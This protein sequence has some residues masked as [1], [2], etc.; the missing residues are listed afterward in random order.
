LGRIVSALPYGSTLRID[1]GRRGALVVLALLGAATANSIEL[2]VSS[3]SAA[4]SAVKAEGM[5]AGDLGALVAAFEA[6]SVDG[7]VAVADGRFW[8]AAGASEAQELTA[9]LASV[10][11]HL[12]ALAPMPVERAM[13]RVGV[14]LAADADQ[15]MTTA[16]FRAMRLLLDRIAELAGIGASPAKIHAE[17]AWRMMSRREPRMNVL[18][19]TGA[20]FA[21]ATGGAD[22]IAVL[23]FDVL[24][25]AASAA[26][27]RLA[28][29]TQLILAD[30][31][32]LHRFADPG[33]GSGAIE[34]LTD[35]LAEAAWARFQRIE[36][37][38]GL[39]AELR[40]GSLLRE[41]AATRAAR[42]ERVRSGAMKMVGVNA[43][44]EAVAAPS[45][46]PPEA[47][48]GALVFRRLAEDEEAA[49]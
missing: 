2:I 24:D 17:T 31:T 5:M 45:P 33:A 14:A 16:K 48:A 20:A 43:F 8:H 7:T 9:V 6:A 22:S 11:E 15:L 34:A 44:T 41:V 40:G 35:A 47:A 28:R 19:A 13:A 26:A 38:G 10:A 46:P 42:L 1:A 18:R 29:N 30:E 25:G 37:A 49:P 4:A 36:A 21:A 39:M 32:Q 23:P 12:R 3:D 27:R